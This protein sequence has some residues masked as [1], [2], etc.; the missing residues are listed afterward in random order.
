MLLQLRLKDFV[1]IAEAELE[2]APGLIVLTGET[3]AGKSLLI[4]SLKLLLGGRGGGHLIRPGAKEAVLEAFF[5]GRWLAERLTSLGLSPAEEVVVRRV[6]TAERSRIYLNGSL[7]T[8]QM[9]AELTRGLIVLAGQHEYQMLAKPEERL[10]FLDTFSGLQALV[11]SYQDSYRRFRE[12]EKAYQE[13]ARRVQQAE[14]ERDF[15]SFQIRE[16]EETAP[17]PGEDEELEAEL[18]RLKHFKKLK[19]SSQ[20]VSA[21]LL[22]A[23]EHLARARRELFRILDL[24]PE[25]ASLGE[26]LEGLYYE[27]EDLGQEI[28][29][30][31]AQLQGDERRL[32]EIENRLYQLR[33][34]KRK[35][36]PDLAQVLEELERLKRELATL[37]SGEEQLVALETELAG[38]KEELYTLGRELS[39]QRREG[40]RRLSEEV[41]ASL[42][43][44]GLAEAR[45]RVE[46]KSLE[47]AKETGFDRV[48]FM[49][50]SAP[51]SPWRP[52]SQVASGGEL[53]RLFLALKAASARG[54]TALLLFDEVDA[55]IGGETARRVAELLKELARNQQV[56]CVTH[57]P[58]IAAL[59]DQHFVVEKVRE[60][61]EIRTRVRA[62]APEERS[63]ELSRMLGGQE[64][65]DLAQRL[66]GS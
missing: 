6:I 12:L 59:A 46:V 13:L 10:A 62:L 27:V 41:S 8:A 35:Y 61:E 53:S 37:E 29:S 24:A 51:Q 1:L 32:E 57:W 66:L 22:Q 42:A 65:L 45:F 26:R 20:I 38:R 14:K 7:V 17:H 44:L 2:F 30:Y 52:L 55:G 33:R 5:E 50:A 43:S 9:L 4:Q 21:E 19:E 40:A 34:L 23:V 56:I 39:R 16:I 63:L 36:G 47:E 60:G 54:E 25:L 28:A 15:L 3:G 64:A 49:F 11:E 31:G 48:E 58:Q 18:R